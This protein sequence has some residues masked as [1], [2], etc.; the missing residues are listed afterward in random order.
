MVLLSG[1]GRKGSLTCTPIATWTQTMRP[2]KPLLIRVVKT[3]RGG[4]MSSAIQ[5]LPEPPE[6]YSSAFCVDPANFEKT[7]PTP[8]THEGS[9]TGNTHP[10]LI[11]NAQINAE[12][13]SMLFSVL[14]P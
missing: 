6:I 2:V 9:E 3:C 5:H 4:P 8:R 11:L 10:Q 1:Q 12:V 14:T 7:D 13:T